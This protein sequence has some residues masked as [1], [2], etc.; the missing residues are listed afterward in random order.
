MENVRWDLCI[1]GPVTSPLQQPKRYKWALAAGHLCLEIHHEP[2][3]LKRTC[4]WCRV[5]KRTYQLGVSGGDREGRLL[6]SRCSTDRDLRMAGFH[7]IPPITFLQYWLFIDLK[8]QM[9]GHFLCRHVQQQRRYST[10]ETISPAP[11]PTTAQHFSV[12]NPG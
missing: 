6:V 10:C 4:C 8:N 5:Q 1:S 11:S 9:Q 12:I 2:V 3:F 7:T